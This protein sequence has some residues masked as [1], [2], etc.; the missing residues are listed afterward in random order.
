MG[1]EESTVVSIL[2]DPVS[3]G[4]SAPGPPPPDDVGSRS[5][6]GPYTV[7]MKVGLVFC[8]LLFFSVN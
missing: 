2:Y 5:P 6:F 3:P 8:S 4:A 7:I 1:L